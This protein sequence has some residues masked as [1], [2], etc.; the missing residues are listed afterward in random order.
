MSKKNILFLFDIDK[1]LIDS[2]KVKDE[3]A[4]P[5]AIK[6][7][8][9]VYASLS[10][11]EP[12]GM[13]DQ[14]I[15]VELASI[16]ISKKEARD[17]IKACMDEMHEIYMENV[18]DEE[19]IPINGSE[20]IL[21]DLY[22]ENVSLC[23]VTGNIES[24]GREK[25]RQSGLNKFFPVGGFGDNGTERSELVDI[26]VKQA[27]K[28]FETQFDEVVL[29]G[30]SPKDIKAGKKSAVKTVAVTMGVYSKRELEKHKPDLIIESWEDTTGQ[31]LLENLA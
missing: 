22:D 19:V 8:Y 6:N 7:V 3:K 21:R 24:I 2:S 20:E 13:T 18:D 31:D 30:D 23:L 10:D 4:F 12:H 27:E 1:T 26:A 16:G 17:K 28:E 25:L 11:I 15:I 9:G 29:I 5:E 14:Q